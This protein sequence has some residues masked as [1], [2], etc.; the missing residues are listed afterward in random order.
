MSSVSVRGSRSRGPASAR[1]T[2]GIALLP[3]Q[4]KG[5]DALMAAEQRARDL[6]LDLPTKVARGG[7]LLPCRRH[8]DMLFLSGHGP[9]DNEGT[10]LFTGQVGSD[11]TLEEGY[12]AARA[13]GLQ[14]LRS[15]RDNLGDLDR[16]DYLV[17][18]LGFVNSAPGFY[19]QPEVI[20]GFSDLMTEVFGD[21]GTHSRSAIGTSVLPMNIPVE[22]ELIVAVRD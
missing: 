3:L 9:S 5:I 8:G 14:L 4:Q 16:V 13:V 12:Q 18:A 7:A 22:I 17:K 20:N 19:Q 2:I 11:L 21:R 15:I 1:A 10:F 6:G